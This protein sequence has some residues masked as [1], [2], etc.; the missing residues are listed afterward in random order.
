MTGVQTCAL[1][2]FFGAD[3][4]AAIK[5][6]NEDYGMWMVF[7]AGL[8]P[9]PFKLMT[10]WSGFWHQQYDLL[11]FFGICVLARGSRFMTVSLLMRLF[12]KKIQDELEKRFNFWSVVFMMLLIGGFLLMKLLR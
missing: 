11:P 4:V 1:P 3:A 12:G 9:I 10:I 6:L 8:T 2:I 7:V 5:R